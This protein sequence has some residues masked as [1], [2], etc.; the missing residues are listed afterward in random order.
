MINIRHLIFLA[1][2]IFCIPCT[3]QAQ[4]EDKL[5]FWLVYNGFINIKSDYEL[6][7]ESQFRTWEPLSNTQTWFIRPFISYRVTENFLPGIGV[8]YHI[9]RSFAETDM[10]REKTQEFRVSLQSILLQKIGSAF[11]Q[12]RYRYEFRFWDFEGKQRVRYRIQT[13]I[14][15]TKKDLSPGVFFA[16]LGNEFLIDTRPALNISED[17][18][19]VM[20][21]YTVNPS[22]FIQAGYLGIVRAGLPNLNRIQVMFTQRLFID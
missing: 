5:G 4:E 6:L 16:T 14:P 13:S 12:H 8:E 18:W 10:D 3:G 7:L 15:I 20:A 11:L 1:T 2:F 9:N 22:L 21:G 19:Y 17:W